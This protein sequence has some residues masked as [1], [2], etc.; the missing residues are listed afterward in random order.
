MTRNLLVMHRDTVFEPG[1]I[2]RYFLPESVYHRLAP[3]GMGRV[4]VGNSAGN[5]NLRLEPNI[6]Y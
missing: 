2:A 1:G 4:P 3:R 6:G 5:N